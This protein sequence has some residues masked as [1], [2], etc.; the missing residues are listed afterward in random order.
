M[1][2]KVLQHR[3]FKNASALLIMQLF[4]YLAPFLVLPYLSR[5]LGSEGFGLMVLSLSL[6]IFCSIVT[7]F[8]FNL[9]A[10]Y[11]VA[12]NKKFRKYVSKLISAVYVIKILLLLFVCLGLSVYLTLSAKHTGLALVSVFSSVFFQTFTSPWLFQGIEKLKII[13]YSSIV[14]QIVYITLIFTFVKQKEDYDIALMCHAIGIFIYFL[15]SNFF[16]I[17]EGYYLTK[18]SKRFLRFCFLYSNQFFISR[19]TLSASSSLSVL[20][21]AGSVQ[22]AVIGLYG[23]SEKL[24][25]AYKQLVDPLSQALYPYMASTGNSALLM[26]LVSIIA[27]VMV[28]PTV[29][30]YYYAAIILEIIFGQEFAESFSILRV[31][32]VTGYFAFLSVCFG[33]PAFASINRVD[34]A[35]KS[36]II[37]GSFQLLFLFLLY[38]F[39]SV[40]A[41][42]IAGS[43]LITELITLF[44]RLRWFFKLS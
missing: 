5:L 34:L 11:L 23:A 6:I 33:Y 2:K 41:I 28:I 10:T 24:F 27:L 15:L 12:R 8:G 37:S 1:F 13:T 35:N 40:T 18:P 38:F 22:P 19:V 43:I 30:I 4:T 14:R 20:V 17:R 31:F 36:V 29:F 44:L 21:L 25:N 39:G 3:I 42:N 26:R 32:I 9:S 7:D 16:L